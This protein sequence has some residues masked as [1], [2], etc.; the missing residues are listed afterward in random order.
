MATNGVICMIVVL[1]WD[2]YLY[3]VSPRERPWRPDVFWRK[4]L[5]T[6]RATCVFSHMFKKE[7]RDWC[8][9]DASCSMYPWGALSDVTV[10]LWMRQSINSYFCRRCWANQNQRGAN[11]KR[12]R[13]KNSY[14]DNGQNRMESRSSGRNGNLAEKRRRR[15]RWRLLWRFPW[16][17]SPWEVL[18]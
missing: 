9:K 5:V 2:N 3:F 7:H 12:N 4:T 11:P 17:I 1:I 16:R 13:H 14:T 6:T 10:V 15:W 8:I 18:A